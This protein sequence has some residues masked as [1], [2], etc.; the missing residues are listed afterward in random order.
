MNERTLNLPGKYNREE[1]DSIIR[2]AN[3]LNMSP[4]DYVRKRLKLPAVK[5]GA[6]V[7]NKNNPRGRGAKKDGP[8]HTGG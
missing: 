5:M 7:G 2:S 1:I 4:A 6:P 8:G 3:K